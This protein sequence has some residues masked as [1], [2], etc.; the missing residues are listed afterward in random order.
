MI[1][2]RR[3]G[4]KFSLS[5]IFLT[6][7][8]TFLL[9]GSLGSDVHAEGK[10]MLNP[11]NWFMGESS[12][13]K[14]ETQKPE[15][16]SGFRTAEVSETVPDQQNQGA[17]LQTS[18]GNIA[19]EL[20][21]DQAPITVR[22]FKKLVESG[23]YNSP[24]MNFHRVVPGFVVQTG[25]PTGT[26]YGGSPDTI[27]LEVD[28]KL[29]HNKKG[30]LSMARSGEPDSASSQFFITLAPQKHLDGKY[31][32]FGRV[33]SGLDVLDQIKKG[34]R[35]YGIKLIDTKKVR[36][37]PEVIEADKTWVDSMKAIFIGP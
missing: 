29:S 34:T 24:K 31:A 3:T 7:G 33:L 17:L 20:Y 4:L 21:E 6:L 2:L 37:D 14:I 35:L 16:K 32:V 23:F 22:N 36:V 28:N 8:V 18:K 15:P 10:S 5:A 9:L 12:E 19:I 27:P 30:M 25:D 26:G 1:K 11:M 13:Q